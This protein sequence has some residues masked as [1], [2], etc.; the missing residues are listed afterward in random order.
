MGQNKA[1]AAKAAKQRRAVAA[2]L[3]RKTASIAAHRGATD[4]SR[5][6]Q[7]EIVFDEIEK[8]RFMQG[9]ARICNETPN[10]GPCTAQ[11]GETGTSALWDQPRNYAPTHRDVLK[12]LWMFLQW[13]WVL[14]QW[15]WEY[16]N[17]PE[18]NIAEDIN[19]ARSM[20]REDTRPSFP[21]LASQISALRTSKQSL[22]TLHQYD[23]GRF[24]IHNPAAVCD[25]IPPE[26]ALILSEWQLISK[27][28]WQ[29]I[30][31]RQY[32]DVVWDHM[33]R[34]GVKQLW[35]CGAAVVNA[36]QLPLD[37]ESYNKL[38]DNIDLAILCP[39]QVRTHFYIVVR[40][41]FC[42][43]TPLVVTVVCCRQ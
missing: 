29:L 35:I 9:L 41:H 13:L 14:L 26:V 20:W 3:S 6:K 40:T 36:M 28:Q 19:Q 22:L 17:E 1:K 34:M 43:R 24:A 30:G 33:K 37:G 12:W 7:D 16:L 31:K 32:T 11:E 27:Q 39:D 25:K 8:H 38:V 15:L 42:T 5:A 2:P 18:Y 4:A 21:P 10:Y 23:D